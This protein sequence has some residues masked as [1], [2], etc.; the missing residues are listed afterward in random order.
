VKCRFKENRFIVGAGNV[1]D[2][3][4]HGLLF[5]IIKL[6]QTGLQQQ[7]Q[8]QQQQI[9][10]KIIQKQPQTSLPLQTLEPDYLLLVAQF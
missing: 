2:V 5:I 10:N 4:V 6:E 1:L 3:T 7:Q 9:K 8:Q